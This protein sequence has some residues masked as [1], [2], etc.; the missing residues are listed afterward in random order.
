MP[1]SPKT[2]TGET[3]TGYVLVAYVITADGHAVDPTVLKSTNVQLN[4]VASNATASWSFEPAK[5]K[6][7]PVGTTAAQEFNFKYEAPKKGFAVDNIVLYQPNDVLVQRLSGAD[8][9][10]AYIKQLQAVLIDYFKDATTPETFHTI[11]AVRPGNLSRI[12][13][14]SS[15]RNGA[16][17]YLDSLQQKLE[18][19]KPVDVKDGPIAFAISGSIAGGDGKK[20]KSDK[21]FQPPIP[22]EWQDAGKDLKPPVLVPDGYLDVVWPATK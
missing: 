17:M 20:P 5:F 18:A 4:Q 9:L 1:P 7:I 22:R 10:A 8:Q 2:A 3:L 12:W 13:F 21:N 11:V 6:G 16:S 15:T 14:V 19:I